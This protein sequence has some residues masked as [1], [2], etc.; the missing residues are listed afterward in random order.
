MKF[1]FATITFFILSFV[2]FI[3]GAP[4]SLSERDVSVPPVLLPNGKSVW[5]VGTTQTITWYV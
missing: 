3:A 4:V 2:S 1:I 5:K